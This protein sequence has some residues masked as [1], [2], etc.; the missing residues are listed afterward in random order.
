MASQCAVLVSD[1]KACPALVLQR[2]L[3]D[4]AVWVVRDI[5]AWSRASRP[6]AAAALNNPE[7]SK[8]EFQR[9]MKKELTTSG[10]QSRS[11]SMSIRDPALLT[12]SVFDV[13]AYFRPGA[14]STRS[15]GMELFSARRSNLTQNVT[16]HP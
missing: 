10:P 11:I 16:L 4:G 2:G 6:M 8:A 15:K 9:E 5:V 14:Y 12:S 7:H 13:H 1:G 3:G